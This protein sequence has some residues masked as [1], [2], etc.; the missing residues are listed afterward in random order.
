MLVN[1]GEALSQGRSVWKPKLEFFTSHQ[2]VLFCDDTPV[3]SAAVH[4][5][6]RDPHMAAWSNALDLALASLMCQAWV[7][8]V[9]SSPLSRQL[10]HFEQLQQPGFQDDWCA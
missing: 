10:R 2:V 4:G 8:R 3:M 1:R 6:A 5:Y 9:L 7:E